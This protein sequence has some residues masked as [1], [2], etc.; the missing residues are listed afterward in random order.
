M[1]R[2][3]YG[4]NGYY[5]PLPTRPDTRTKQEIKAN[6]ATV[7]AWF[8]VWRSLSKSKKDAWQQLSRAE[9]DATYAM[10]ADEF[11]AYMDGLGDVPEV[12]PLVD[13]P[14]VQAIA[15]QLIDVMYNR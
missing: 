4:N 13:T 15:R 3:I 11:A 12:W 8:K 7:K 5:K 14:T 10:P 9:K 2:D 6:A 1:T